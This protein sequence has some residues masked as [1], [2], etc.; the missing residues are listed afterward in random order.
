[1][2]YLKIYCIV[3]ETGTGKDT[4]FQKLL[5]QRNDLTPIITYTTRPPRIGEKNGK[6][7]YFVSKNVFNKLKK[8]DKII[9]HRTYETVHGPWIYFMACDN[10]I[11]TKSDKKYIVINTLQGAKKLKEIYGKDVIIIH[12]YI[13]DRERLLRCF[14]RETNGNCDYV[15]MCRRYVSDSKDYS[16]ENFEKLGLKD[17][18]VINDNIYQC[19]EQI[20]KIIK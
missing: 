19:V 17:L 5:L 11:D 12:L 20:S 13:D 15:E 14:A 9:E 7:Y 6:E 4:V 2:I 1:V 3:G 10:Q 16:K 8:G 18:R